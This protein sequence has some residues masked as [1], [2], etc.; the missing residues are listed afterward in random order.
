M[1]RKE[2]IIAAYKDIGKDRSLYDGMM[3]GTSLVGR[4][5]MKKIWN[6]TPDDAL[7]YRARA[8]EAIPADFNGALLEVP[9]GTGILSM[10]VWKTLPDAEI[11]CMDISENMMFMARERAEMTDV[12]NIHFVQGDAAA[13]PFGDESFDVVVSMN[14]FHAFSDKEAAFDEVFRVL[15]PGGLFCGCFY[16]EGRNAH[17]D[18]MVRRYYVRTGSFIPPFETPE[19]LRRRLEARYA[20]TDVSNVKSIVCF[21]C[22][23]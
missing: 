21:R 22:R 16:C 8:L 19:S 2:E 6:M 3:A 1:T 13:M 7:E 5:L 15:K 9:V 23:K 18:K 4:V 10:P 14:G 12:R 11:T 17:T 20:E